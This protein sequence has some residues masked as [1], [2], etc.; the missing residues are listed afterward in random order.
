MDSTT[1]RPDTPEFDGMPDHPKEN[2]TKFTLEGLGKFRLR[3]G[4][5][6]GERMTLQITCKVIHAGEDWLETGGDGGDGNPDT[7]PSIK[8]R[9]ETLIE[10]E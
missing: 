7:R 4:I 10:V 2:P 5:V 6:N 9:A 1:T 3:D 8:L